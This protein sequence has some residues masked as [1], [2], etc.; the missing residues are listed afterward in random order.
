MA[1][2]VLEERKKLLEIETAIVKT[3]EQ[4]VKRLND[5]NKLRGVGA[6]LSQAQIDSMESATKSLTT[7]N[8]QTIRSI[9]LNSRLSTSY[10]DVGASAS[11]ASPAIR[12][13][14]DTVDNVATVAG[15]AVDQLIAYREELQKISEG[16]YSFVSNI[17][18]DIGGSSRL[19]AAAIRD[20]TDF[21]SE[22]AYYQGNSAKL[23]A[24]VAEYYKNMQDLAGR[25]AKGMT[26]G[27][28]EFVAQVG[29]GNQAF[30]SAQ[31]AA[32]EFYGLSSGFVKNSAGKIVPDG[33]F[34]IQGVP[35]EDVFGSVEEAFRPLAEMLSDETLSLSVAK[36]M[37]D[38]K[39]AKAMIDDTMRMSTAIKAF[40]MT[41][42]EITDAI[43]TNYIMSG[44]AGTDYFNDLTKAAML[45][46]KAFG[47][48]SQQIISDI[49]RMSTNFDIFGYRTPEELA[50]VSAA[51]KDAHMTISDLQSVMGKFN[52][53]ESAAGA[54]G[55]LNAALGTNFD[56][57]EMMTLK[58]EDPAMFIQKLREGFMSAGK[59]FEDLPQTYRSMITQQLGI[60]SEALRGL[61]DGSIRDIDELSRQQEGA[62]KI[63]E[64]SG[65][66]EAERRTALDESI[67]SRVKI[68][69]DMIASAG[70]MVEQA[71]RAANR[72]ANT[73][74]FYIE[75]TAQIGDAIN[76]ISADVA[77]D[78]IPQ[79]NTLIET[80]ANN[81]SKLIMG[82]AEAAQKDLVTRSLQDLGKLISGM[83]TTIDEFQK[84]YP[85]MFNNVPVPEI[86]GGVVKRPI[87]VQ[88][89]YVSQGGSTVVTA[90]FGEFDQRSF[91]LNRQ[92]ELIAKPRQEN[93][94]QASPN[95]L[96]PFD[97]AQ[98][99]ATPTQQQPQQT[100]PSPPPPPPP[101]P[102][103]A[104]PAATDSIRASLQ[105]AGTSLRIDL[106]ISQLTD[107][108]LR[109][110][111]MNKPNIFGGL[112]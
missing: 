101:P 112:T 50:K 68:T 109:D 85:T 14:S 54:V 100:T 104:I 98:M 18:S 73:S 10:N 102:A 36:K 83:L 107:L 13:N 78:L 106:D 23:A 49:T 4:E 60:T 96:S 61:M 64:Q 8:D 80:A 37:S 91:L 38:E 16:R 17:A 76:G 69:E 41:T 63:Y 39:S 48:S 30:A 7:A 35:I 21:N 29:I 3:L 1:E 15:T 46:E 11:R 77:K 32:R 75:R 53:F 26:D 25:G 58:F 28:K 72:F 43:R 97:N 51:A 79:M 82:A 56:A 40:G 70:D 84:T 2:P 47:Y 87:P 55:Q 31:Y 110:I 6:Q 108:I 62:N 95:S 52:T 105:G 20:V 44:E 92:D 12:S 103:P 74:N 9:G 89:L 5:V 94:V 59:T 86:T 99:P 19:Y 66:S 34:R 45:G 93:P 67:K 71:D 111:M 57:L 22:M 27:Q 88:D 33:F 42:S 90:N 65:T 81:Y 24:N